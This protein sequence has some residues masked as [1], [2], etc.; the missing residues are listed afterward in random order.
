[1]IAILE[2]RRRSSQ[3][4]AN[5]LN[6][7]QAQLQHP[8][9]PLQII[10]MAFAWKAAGLTYAISSAIALKKPLADSFSSYNRYVS[11]ASRV[12]RRSLKE[13]KRIAAERRGESDLRFA[14]WEV[15]RNGLDMVKGKD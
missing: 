4:A 11:I 15:S 9:K 1:V 7:R 3:L 12:V 2:L 10:T 6:N 5:I 14:K 13:D 8:T